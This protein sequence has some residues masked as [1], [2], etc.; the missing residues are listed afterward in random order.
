MLDE[1]LPKGVLFGHMDALAEE[2][3]AK[4]NGWIMSGNT[5]RLQDFH[6]HGGEIPT[7]GQAGEGCHEMVAATHLIYVLESVVNEKMNSAFLNKSPLA[8][9]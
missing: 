6:T 2:T 3:T 7:T 5:C 1:R 9:S 4:Y 8:D